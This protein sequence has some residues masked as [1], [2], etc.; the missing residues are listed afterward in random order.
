MLRIYDLGK[1]KLLRKCENKSFPRLIKTIHT[2]GNRIIVSDISESFFYVK[3]RRY[4][5]QLLIFADDSA[6]RWVTA[7][8]MLDYDTVA[9]GDKFGNIFVCR[10]PKEIAEDAEE[11]PTAA[12]LQHLTYKGA[13]H[14]VNEIIQFHVGEVIT[15]ISKSSLVPGGASV[16]IYGTIHGAIGALV[17]FVSRDDVDFLSMLEMHMRQTLPPL[18][19]RDHMAYRSYYFPVKVSYLSFTFYYYHQ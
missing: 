19:G 15:H 2:Q 17:P 7:S 4:E 18:C 8:C 5:N 11:D 12:H 13:P 9:G 3:Y 6:P 14:K 10:L 1:K 16:L